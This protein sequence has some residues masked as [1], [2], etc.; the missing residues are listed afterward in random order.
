MSPDEI[1]KI[2]HYF[3]KQSGLSQ[4]E[5]AKLAGVGKTVVYDVEKGKETVK[6]KTLLQILDVLNIKVELKAPFEKKTESN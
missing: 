2:V 1:A 5:L 6:L 3:R 4:Q